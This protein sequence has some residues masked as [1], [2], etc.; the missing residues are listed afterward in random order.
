M[1]T[2]LA[3]AGDAPRRA[4]SPRLERASLWLLGFGGGFAFIEP[5]PYELAFVVCLFVLTVGGL[6]LH[7]SSLP[8]VVL[9]GVFNLGGIFSL[10]P[11]LHDGD[12]VVFIAVSIYL[13]ATSVFFAAIVLDRGAERLAALKSGLIWAAATASVAGILGYFDVAGLASLFTVNDRASGTFK[14][15]NVLGTF[16]V[17]PLVLLAQNLLTGTGRFLR[18]ALLFT[19]ILFGAVFLSFSRGAWGNAAGAVLVM[20]VL[21][22]LFAATPRIRA[23]MAGLALVAP[24]VGVIALGTALSVPAVR[25]MF[26]VRA[27]LNQYYDVGPTGRFG[28]HARS[29]PTLLDRPNGYGPRQFRYHWPED[30][31]NVYINAF[32]SYG[33]IGGVA[34]AALTAATLV[35]GF[36]A[37]A[38]RSSLQPMAIAAWSALF[39][40]ILQGIL[41]DTDHWRHYYL[42]LGLTWGLF[43]LARLEAAGAPRGRSS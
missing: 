29:W 26:E 23:R 10:A 40:T 21:T 42:L 17:F 18:D 38:M 41:I 32:A 14:D 22:F 5:S 39:T 20:A 13:M 11:F 15:P 43:A 37:A 16:V 1:S 19:I 25:E 28:N 2:A 35:V 31:H 8:M 36:A 30:P 7:R 24:I 3:S 27:S 12:S 4:F 33:W 9:L 34:Y 6:R